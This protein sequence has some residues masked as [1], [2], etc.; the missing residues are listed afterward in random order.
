M[1][2]SS[3]GTQST[4]A[5]DTTSQEGSRESNA[6]FGRPVTDEQIAERAYELYVNRGRQDGGALDDWLQAEREVRR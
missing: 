2:R 1:A 5:P 3:Q 4:A 6:E